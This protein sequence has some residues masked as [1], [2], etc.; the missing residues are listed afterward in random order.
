MDADRQVCT[1]RVDGRWFG[2]DVL[3]VQEIVPA[4]PL[5]RVP[6]AHRMVSGL[7][8]LR[9]QIVTAVDLR[10]RLGLA[11]RTEGMDSF[12]VVMQTIDGAVSL[13]VDDVGDVIDLIAEHLDQPPDGLRGSALDVVKAVY[14]QPDRLIVILSPEQ[15]LKVSDENL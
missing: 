5:T 4:Q 7:L 13:I 15:V 9:G 2:L 1:F 3:Q 6:L 10:R 8:N 12:N 14:R 11:D